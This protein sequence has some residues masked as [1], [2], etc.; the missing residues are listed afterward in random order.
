MG[1][2]ALG[3]FLLVKRLCGWFMSGTQLG[4]GTALPREIAHTKA[5]L[6]EEAKQYLISAMA[7]VGFAV[8]TVTVVCTATP[9]W[10]AKAMLGSRNVALLYA[11]L[12]L[13]LATVVHTM[14]MSYYVGLQ[15]MRM[16][17]LLQIVNNAALPMLAV[18]A[19]ARSHSTSLVVAA[20]S[21]VQLAVACIWSVRVIAA[22]SELSVRKVI[23]HSKIL[24]SYGLRRVPADVAGGGLFTVGPVIV[25]HYVSPEKIAFLLLGTIC[26]MSASMAFAP[27]SVVML[28][29]VSSLLGM[30]RTSDVQ[31]YVGHLRS[32]VMHVSFLV[33]TQ[34]LIFANPV[35]KW[36]VGGSYQTALPVMCV[37]I[38]GV[39]A[40]MYFVALRTVIDAASPIAYNTRNVVAAAA[41]L[42]A[43]T[44]ITARV[45]PADSLVM[46]AAMIT[47]ASVWLLAILT[48]NTLRKLQMG[49]LETS[50]RPFVI[51]AVPALVALAVQF[52]TG[53]NVGKIA[54]MFTLAVNGILL[55]ILVRK[56][57]PGWLLL[58]EQRGLVRS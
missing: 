39:P 53:F 2:V 18:A 37:M 5:D 57:Q 50:L 14:L 41:F 47:T 27:L 25:A 35:I 6:G 28:T 31:T 46:A 1:I 13:I 15:K 36:W 26:L 33:V 38:L 23:A 32:A 3:E 24:L 22:V 17:N 16:A 10:S 21:A 8:L 4:L 44:A 7:M 55:A 20:A 58:L 30:G 51:A 29:K 54:F 45:V 43:G 9:R 52:G 56:N 12:F 11:L 34:A 42:L 40:Y 19:T 49:R 48:N